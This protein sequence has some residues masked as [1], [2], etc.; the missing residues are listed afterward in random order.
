MTLAAGRG[1]LLASALAVALHGLLFLAVRPGLNGGR[2]GGMPVAPQTSYLPRAPGKLPM[3]GNEVR[4]LGSPVLFSLPSGMGFSRALMQQDV[5]TR[6][7]TLSRPQESEQFLAIDTAARDTARQL[8][9]PDLL[10]S[11][12]KGG[13]PALPEGIFPA[14][15]NRPSARRVTIVPELKERLIG[16]I[17]LPPAL[18]QEVPQGWEVSASMSVSE[19]G[20]V[21]HVFLNRPLEP[22]ALNQQVLQLLYGLRFKP[23][24]AV[25]GSIEIYSPETTAVAVETP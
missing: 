14:S 24:A 3:A 2:V 10:L 1:L 16:G 13:A 8:V 18:N 21:E 25:D 7:D 12:G 11:S 22:A 4:I 19:L 5:A 9:T 23:G 17:V 20:T 15:E 6:L